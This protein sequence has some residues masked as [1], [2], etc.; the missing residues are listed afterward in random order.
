[1]KKSI[2]Q[3]QNITLTVGI[4]LYINRH[5]AAGRVCRIVTN[6]FTRE[7]LN[8]CSIKICKCI[9]HNTIFLL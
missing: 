7:L 9:I 4:F 8:Y 2:E 5:N 3:I 1:M 6:L